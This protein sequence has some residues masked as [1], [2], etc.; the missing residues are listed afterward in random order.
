MLYLKCVY[1]ICMGDV[2]TIMLSLSLRYIS[3]VFLYE[4]YMKP[5]EY[6]I[7]SEDLA[8]PHLDK[9][10]LL[11]EDEKNNEALQEYLAASMENP[12]SFEAISGIIICC[13]RLGDIE[14]E[15]KYTQEMYNIC[16]TRAELA[17]YYRNLGWYYLEKYKPYLSAAL[18][19]YS[20]FF[21]EGQAAEDEIRY[22][23]T[24]LNKPMGK[25]T[26]EQIQKI[27]EDNNIP[28]GPSSI[29]LALLIK[30]GEEAE[31][32]GNFMQAVDCYMMVYDLTEDE[33]IGERIKMLG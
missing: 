28:T 20:T 8:R 16:C 15:Y 32:K 17:V 6:E 19:R 9:A 23:E 25:E 7:S 3:E 31:Q 29:T 33:E 12:V 2:S 11:L 24:A 14:G 22:L 26:P 13:K 21:Q 30:A 1:F 5:D 27:L 4:Y 10:G 18:Y